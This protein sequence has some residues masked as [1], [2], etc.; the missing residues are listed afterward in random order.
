MAE[1]IISFPGLG[2]EEFSINRIALSIGSLH[3]YWYGVIIAAAFLAAILY[4]LARVRSFGLD[5]DRVLDVILAGVVGG[6]IGARLYYVVFSWDMYKDDPMKIFRIW[7]GGL[8]IYGGI[9]GGF[10]VA[11]IV[12]KL[13]RV[14]FI[15]L[16][17]LAVGGL[18][19]GQG[20]GRWGNFVNVEAFG[21]NTSLPWGMASPS[22][23]RYLSIHQAALAAQGIQVDPSMPV[24]PTFFYESVWCLLG[25][26]VILWYTKRRRYDGELLLIYVAWYGLGRSVIEGLRT[27][28]LMWGNFRVSQLLAILLCVTSLLLMIY[29]RGKIRKND[30]PD[31]LKLYVYTEEGQAILSGQFYRRRHPDE[32]EAENKELEEPTPSVPLEELNQQEPEQTIKE[33]NI[34][35]ETEDESNDH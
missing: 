26:L 21:S 8:A 20:I 9:I 31:Y 14:K 34:G 1:Q 17:D 5:S 22:V 30:D 15:P 18:I 7:E 16:A 23:E 2:I 11:F 25:F 13:R 4:I 10:L 24:H 3:I 35:E 6:I 33:T 12:A 29:I 32:I 19:L 27:D 28:S